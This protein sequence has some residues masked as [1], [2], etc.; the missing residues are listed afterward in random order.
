MSD[1]PLPV[2]L[3]PDLAVLSNADLVTEIA[4]RASI[5]RHA[6]AA[7]IRVLIE[8]DRRRLYL[9]EGYSSLFAYCTEVLHYSEHAAFNRIEV[10]RAAARWPQ[11]L[12]C[13]ED[14][15]LHLAGARL[16]AP[17]LTEDNIEDALAEARYRSKREIEEVAAGLAHRN[18]LVAVVAQK[19][20]LHLTISRESRDRLF[21]VQA[22]LSHQL[23]KVDADVI[24]EQALVVLLEKL[25][26][27]RLAATA[28]PRPQGAPRSGSR[29]RHVPAAVVREVWKRDDGR[30]AFVGQQGRCPERHR[31]QFHHVQPFAAGGMPTV[32]NIELRCQAHNAYEAEL[33]FG[34]E[35]AAAAQARAMSGTSPAATAPRRRTRPGA[36]CATPEV[37]RAASVDPL[38]NA[39][40]R[41]K[42]IRGDR[43]E[44]AHDQPGQSRAAAHDGLPGP[45]PT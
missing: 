17:H 7:M 2:T 3:P 24:F 1:V 11:L 9:G 18:L 5:E 31:L 13:L 19:Y 6:T 4:R 14:G 41:G 27:Q 44:G 28:Q 37:E 35:A 39:R 25:E 20:R 32:T 23:P 33:Y 36:T 8:F 21:Q 30:C 43:S 38:Q 40:S 34:P 15:S 10:A 22:L 45:R 26:R 16:L 12:D 42:R 29:S